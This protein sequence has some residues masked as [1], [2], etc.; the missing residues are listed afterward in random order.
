MNKIKQLYVCI[1]GGS[2]PPTA[3]HFLPGC[4]LAICQ[5]AF[6]EKCLVALTCD[7]GCGGHGRSETEGDGGSGGLHFLGIEDTSSLEFVDEDTT[8]ALTL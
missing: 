6:L 4:A 8:N 1:M 7:T 5:F 3:Q 2:D